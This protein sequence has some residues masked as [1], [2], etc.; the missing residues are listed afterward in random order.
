MDAAL[1]V[2]TSQIHEEEYPFSYLLP[3]GKVLTIG[4]SEDV[5]YTLDVT[6]QTWTPV[7]GRAA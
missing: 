5:T 3:N 2:S 7:G 4:P 6:N 1:E